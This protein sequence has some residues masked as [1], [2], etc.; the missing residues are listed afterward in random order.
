M[1]PLKPLWLA[2]VM[3]A[4]LF[5][6]GHDTFSRIGKRDLRE[7]RR[8]PSLDLKN[9][10]LPVQTYREKAPVRQFLWELWSNRTRGFF[11]LTSYSREG[12]AA[13]CRYFVEPMPDGRWRVLA[14]CKPSMCPYTS[15]S[16]C[17]KFMK[18]V[19]T[20]SYDVVEADKI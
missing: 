11:D 20:K 16:A 18:V 9:A 3:L 19:Q 6:A 7:Y 8:G 5:A 12:V 10:V 14:E 2:A 13:R 15:R 1:K 4:T 17:N